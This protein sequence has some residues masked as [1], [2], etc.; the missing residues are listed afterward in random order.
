MKYQD[1]VQEIREA[2]SRALGCAMLEAEE[3]GRIMFGLDDDM[4]AV[5]FRK[6]AWSWAAKLLRRRLS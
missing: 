2:L 1:N 3:D 4:G 6:R 5:L